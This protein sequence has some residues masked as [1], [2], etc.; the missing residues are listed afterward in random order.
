MRIGRGGDQ[1][2][3]DVVGL[4]DLLLAL[5]AARAQPRREPLR[6]RLVD[7]KYVAEFRRGMGGN[8]VGV[9]CAGAAGAKQRK[10][11]HFGVRRAVAKSEKS[12][13]ESKRYSL[14]RFNP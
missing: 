6:G 3:V 13:A 8:V 14:Y 12:E 4:P 11:H 2:R 10:T 1:D 9:D 5:R 7:V